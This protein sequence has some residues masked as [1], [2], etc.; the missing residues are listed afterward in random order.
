MPS[1][2]PFSSCYPARLSDQPVDGHHVLLPSRVVFH[3]PPPY[4]SSSQPPEG[5][6]SDPSLLL[7]QTALSMCF[8]ILV[9]LFL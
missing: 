7:S 4:S 3:H 5:G 8:C 2:L 9:W 6:R 1:P